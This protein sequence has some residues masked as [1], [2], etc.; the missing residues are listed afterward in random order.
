MKKHLFLIACMVY[1]I[2]SSAQIDQ[3][4]PTTGTSGGN[5][6]PCSGN[7]GVGTGT[8]TVTGKLQVNGTKGNLYIDDLAVGYNYYD[9]YEVHNFRD[10]S[11]ASKFFIN[12]ASGNVGI[13]TTTPQTKLDLS[14]IFGQSST[15]YM[16]SHT[17]SG[18]RM[19]S[20]A[21][22][23]YWNGS[24]YTVPDNTQPGASMELH[25]G[26]S[27]IRF[28]SISSGGTAT[29][30]H[31]FGLDG[32]DSYLNAT[33]GSLGIG[34][35]T[36]TR[37]GGTF[38]KIVDLSGSGLVGYILK[39]GGQ[40]ASIM[41]NAGSGVYFDIIGASTA[42]NNFLS[43]RTSNTNSNNAASIEAMRIKSDGVVMIGGSSASYDSRYKLVV[44]GTIG[45]KEVYVTLTR[46]WPDYVFG[47]GYKLYSILDLDAFIQ[48]N[49]HLPNMP[50]A[51][52]VKKSGSINIG[53]TSA[54]LLEKVE[55]L[56]L[57]IIELK[58]ENIQIMKELQ[59]IKGKVK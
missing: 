55:E 30:N 6:I 40:E 44:E 47:T 34:T 10:M 18:N 36:P 7:V 20:F 39:T 2:E 24:S 15:T 21:T 8:T 13:G 54:K 16:S 17:S 25:R 51:A 57:Y 38:G 3:S 52:E 37:N 29:T 59:D 31:Q 1:V 4:C 33:G 12:C 42:S 23:A 56:T 41:S 50:S 22:N 5:K 53:E 27:I 26:A 35:T 48:K 46:P 11:G 45:A 9:A 28:L 49:K 32:T 19:S 58:K 14:G 43:F